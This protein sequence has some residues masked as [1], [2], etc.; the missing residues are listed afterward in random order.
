MGNIPKSFNIIGTA[1][2]RPDHLVKGD[3]GVDAARIRNRNNAANMLRYL[4]ELSS[5]A[6]GDEYTRRSFDGVARVLS[7]TVTQHLITIS[8]HWTMEQSND[9]FY[10]THLLKDIATERITHDQ[11]NEVS[12]W[13]QNSIKFVVD[14]TRAQVGVDL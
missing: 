10:Y 3:S 2:T 1:S 8:A 14:K 13:L 12:G 6:R 7:A 9:G 11:W 4:C 5:Q